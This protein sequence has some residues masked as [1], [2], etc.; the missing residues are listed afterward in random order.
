MEV[1]IC[2]KK[3]DMELRS[4]SSLLFFLF[5]SYGFSC[6]SQC[7]DDFDIQAKVEIPGCSDNGKITVTK[8][9]GGNPPLQF[10]INNQINETG[11]FTGLAAAEYLLVVTD[12]GNCSDSFRINL[13]PNTRRKLF[14]APNAFSPN[15][16]GINDTWQINGVDRHKGVGLTIFNKWG[17]EVFNSPDY[18]NQYAWDGRNGNSKLPE[19]TYYFVISVLSNCTE[20][21]Q[22]GTVTIVR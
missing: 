22:S 4:L 11:V 18:K 10:Q 20:F 14:D 13:I 12:A 5:V 19:A 17:Q 3:H 7:L 6:F 1:I 15:G 21:N 2:T 9:V 16:D 8:V